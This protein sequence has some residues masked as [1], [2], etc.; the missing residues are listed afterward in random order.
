MEKIRKFTLLTIGSIL[1]AVGINAFFVPHQLL[2]GG[3][4]GIGLIIH[5]I[6]HIQPGL[7]V[8]VLSIPLYII[9][10][11]SFRPLFFN[12]LHGMLLSSFLIDF[13][14]PI[15][16]WVKLPIIFSSILGG[17]FV[18]LGIGLLLRAE[19]ASGGID[20][21]A[22]MVGKTKGWNVGIIIFALDSLIIITGALV[23]G[24][25]AFLFSLLA[26]TTIGFF[27]SVLSL[28]EGTGHS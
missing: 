4:I 16:F 22:Q 21:L 27:T 23:I 25:D 28:K 14:Y 5:Y 12:S 13:F 17:I 19:A 24:K 2:D 1:I 6:F 9:A 26:I 18:G 3:M 8:I 7:S 11:F 15:S 20:L 10:W